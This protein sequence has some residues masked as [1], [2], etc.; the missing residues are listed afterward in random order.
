VSNFKDVR[1]FNSWP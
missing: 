1:S